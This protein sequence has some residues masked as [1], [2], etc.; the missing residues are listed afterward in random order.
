MLALV[1]S[2]LPLL[3]KGIPLAIQAI[4]KL[5]IGE[6]WRT[7]LKE[8]VK[9]APALVGEAQKQHRIWIDDEVAAVLKAAKGDLLTDEERSA[10]ARAKIAASLRLAEEL[11]R[12]RRR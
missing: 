12:G 2:L 9:N 8:A 1:T 6:V 11:E 5:Q 3:A 4:D 7:L 10:F